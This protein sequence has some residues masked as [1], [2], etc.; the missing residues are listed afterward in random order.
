MMDAAVKLRRELHRQPELSGDEAQT[1]R[2]IVEFFEPL[3][4]DRVITGLGGHGVAFVFAG[5]EP[6]PT[7]LLRCELDALPI[8][9]SNRFPHRS[10][11]DGVSHKCG[12]DGHM[13]ILGEVG[14]ALSTN[15]PRRGRAVLLYQPAEENGR[16]AA[17]VIDD[18]QFSEIRPDFAFAL[19]NLPGYPLGELVIRSGTFCCASRG[20]IVDLR[21]QAAHAAQ[22]DEG[23]S[24][25]KAMCR[26]IEELGRLGSGDERE[27]A[28]ATIVGA[29]LGSGEVFGTAPGEAR[30]LVTLRS[31]TDPTMQKLVARAEDLVAQ[32]TAEDGL[33]YDIVYVDTFPATTNAAAEVEA[34]CRAAAGSS[35]R[36]VERPFPWSED[37]G[38]FLSVA[39]GALF[40]LGAGEN[41]HGLHSLE[42]DFPEELIPLGREMLTGILKEY[43]Y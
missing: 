10:T 43:L 8:Q 13:A 19:H 1:A 17:A 14:A 31:E 25:A 15:R 20:M 5:A 7:V 22:P 3:E 32:V 23:A 42:Y 27:I 34:V 28:F 36:R 11:V 35:I 38:R 41:A 21:G 40:G 39:R 16:G 12:H 37:F 2:R 33:R 30:V 29:R 26:L 18:P 9:E 24:P 4:P 6:G